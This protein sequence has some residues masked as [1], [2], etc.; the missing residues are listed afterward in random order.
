MQ[1]LLYNNDSV[2]DFVLARTLFVE[3]ILVSVQQSTE[4][5][6][7]F[8]GDWNSIPEVGTYHTTINPRFTTDSLKAW[9]KL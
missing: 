4:I 8:V 6:Q 7:P 9:G 5:V 2:L 1:T 3:L